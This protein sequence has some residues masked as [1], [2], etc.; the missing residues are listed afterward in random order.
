MA[1]TL[2]HGRIHRSGRISDKGDTNANVL[3]LLLSP[4][5]TQDSC[6]IS[7]LYVGNVTSELD[8]ACSSATTQAC[9]SMSSL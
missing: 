5:I 1:I 9:T 3:P 4:N 6:T 8:A 2:N 7:V